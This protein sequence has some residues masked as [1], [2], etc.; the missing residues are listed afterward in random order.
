METVSGGCHCGNIRVQ[1]QLTRTAAAYHPRACDCSF[2]RKHGA[3][4]LSDPQG[5]LHIALR[6]ERDVSRYR[7][8][9]GTAEL[10]LCR[11]CGVL[12]AALLSED[13]G[14]YAA[15]NSCALE[16]GV[17]FGAPQAVSPQSLSGGEKVKRWQT[18]WF[19]NVSIDSAQ[20]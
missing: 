15:V 17:P 4:W 7:Q 13:A 20:R 8:G 10:L 9:S 11:R 16:G 14:R 18:L 5:T 3:A 2:C 1:A 12:V 6:D 19:S